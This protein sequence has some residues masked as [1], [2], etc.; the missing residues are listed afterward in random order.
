MFKSRVKSATISI[1][2]DILA[3]IS[4]L[5]GQTWQTGTGLTALR[6]RD[7][8]ARPAAAPSN[9]HPNSQQQVCRRR[10]HFQEARATSRLQYIITVSPI[11][12]S[13]GNKHSLLVASIPFCFKT[14]LPKAIQTT[15]LIILW[16]NPSALNTAVLCSLLH[17]PVPTNHLCL[18]PPLSPYSLVVVLRFRHYTL[19]HWSLQTASG[20]KG[21]ALDRS[22]H[23][24]GK[25][26][27]VRRQNF[28]PLPSGSL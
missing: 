14:T 24:R 18:V 4:K 21:C 5:L 20:H 22:I 11:K 13:R 2:L 10:H 1:S 17:A 26:W 16:T 27:S 7:G 28:L 8:A 9:E 12:M 15:I 3:P 23:L 6:G 25:C 19:Q